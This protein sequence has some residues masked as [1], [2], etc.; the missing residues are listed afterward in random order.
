MNNFVTITIDRVTIR[1]KYCCGYLRYDS[2]FFGNKFSEELKVVNS[3][4][5]CYSQNVLKFCEVY[6]EK[7][8]DFNCR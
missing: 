1:N 5:L 7:G 4:Q 6:Y 2:V 3:T 8:E